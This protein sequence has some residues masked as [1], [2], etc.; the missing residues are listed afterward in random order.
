MPSTVLEVG[1]QRILSKAVIAAASL[2][3]YAH[4]QQ[5]QVQLWTA[6]TGLVKGDRSVLE[7]LAAT[8]AQEDT[9]NPDGC[10]NITIWLTQNPLTLLNLPQ[11]SRWVLWDNLSSPAQGIVNRDYP[12]IIIQ[13]TQ[14]LQ[15]QLQKSLNL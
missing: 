8:T 13:H 10:S 2:F 15:P 7:T 4:R 1:K 11:G 5:I 14:P 9:S 3:F 6:S 12:G